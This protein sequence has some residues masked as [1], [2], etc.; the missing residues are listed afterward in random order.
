MTKIKL[1]IVD[2][3]DLITD[4]VLN[5]M[6]DNKEME[7]I[8]SYSD[9]A[10]L[11][12]GLKTT[13]PDIL[14]LDI[15]MQGM[16]GGE[17]AAKVK[18]EYPKMK[19]IVLTSFDN[20][21]HI[22]SM[23]QH[24][25]E[26]YILKHVK[27]QELTDAIKLVYNGDS[28]IFSDVAKILREDEQI[29]KRQKAIGAMLTNRELEVLQLIAQNYTNVE[30]AEKLVISKRTVEHHRESIFNKLEVKKPSEMIRKAKELNF[31]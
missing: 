8:A 19:I 18:K 20:I 5:M 9:G 4:G 6:R 13:Q 27:K 1:M 10:S 25:I 2:D 30:I 17:V 12:E 14:L 29:I 31:L 21:F 26:G 24:N 22:K 23:L 16:K 11:L 28:Y 3:H 15:N 7:V